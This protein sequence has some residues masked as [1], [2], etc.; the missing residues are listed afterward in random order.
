[1]TTKEW[2]VK[3]K[4]EN[5]SLTQFITKLEAF[6]TDAGLNSAKLES[7]IEVGLSQKES[8]VKKSLN[9]DKDATN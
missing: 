9:P 6:I 7:A 1:M 2:L 3:T 8:E 5:P 4:T